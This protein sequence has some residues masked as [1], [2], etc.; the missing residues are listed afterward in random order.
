MG[1]L[2]QEAS[3]ARLARFAFFP[4]CIYSVQSTC[5]DIQGSPEWA[6][7][8]IRRSGVLQCDTDTGCVFL[9]GVP[10]LV[11]LWILMRVWDRACEVLSARLILDHTTSLRA[12]LEL[13]PRANS[14]VHSEVSLQA[15]LCV[16]LHSEGFF[17]WESWRLCSICAMWC[18]A[19]HLSLFW[20]SWC[21]YM[22]R[23]MLCRAQ[24]SH[25]NSNTATSA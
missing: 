2:S 16:E 20:I 11:V 8:G 15:F 9:I 23:N 14:E 21:E 5:R 13:L 12:M 10:I 24:L 4:E 18:H 1:W 22:A 6:R 25:L 7:S 19:R 17:G 3:W